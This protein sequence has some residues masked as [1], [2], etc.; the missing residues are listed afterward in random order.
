MKLYL[1]NQD[2]IKYLYQKRLKDELEKLEIK[3]DV[4]EKY[5]NLKAIILKVAKE[6]LGTIDNRHPI[7]DWWNEELEALIKNKKNCY[8]KWL[9][10]KTT[11]NW[12]EYK[13]ANAK[14]KRK[15]TEEKNKIWTSKCQQIES[16][17]GG[18]QSTEAW[19][20][21]KILKNNKGYN[22]V[23]LLTMLEAENYYET[24]LTENREI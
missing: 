9:S 8:L 20:F 11:E 2:S 19:R 14:V 7:Q 18:S 3:E 15:V 23:N 16:L 10:N 4:E 22:K 1:F 17:I 6:A 12:I 21:L 5:N 24:L 13:S